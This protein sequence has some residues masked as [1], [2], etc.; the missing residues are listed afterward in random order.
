MTLATV[1]TV[2][3]GRIRIFSSTTEELISY[4]G[5]SGSTITGITGGL[6]LTADPSTGSSGITKTW[7]AGTQCEIVWMHDQFID[8]QKPEI[9]TF[10]T[11][12]ARD[13]ALGGNGVATKAYF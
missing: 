11:T 13:T 10:A 9:V 1:P 5:V 2:T 7:L 8:K 4:T 12:A 3:S 6:S